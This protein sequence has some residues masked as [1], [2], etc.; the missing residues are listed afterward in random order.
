MSTSA[1]QVF[2]FLDRHPACSIERHEIAASDFGALRRSLRSIVVRLHESDDLEAHEIS[3][4]L[5]TYLSEWLTVP[6]PFDGSILDAVQILGDPNAVRDRWGQ[7]IWAFYDAALRAARDLPLGEN[8]VRTKLRAVM[9]GLRTQGQTFKIYCHRRARP[10]FESLIVQPDAPLEEGIFLDSVRDYRDV[11]PF[12]ALIKVGPLRSRGWGSAPDALISA[13]RFGTLVQIVWSGCTD[14]PGFGYDPVG[15]S[16]EAGLAPTNGSVAGHDALDH[17]IS[18]ISHITRSGRDIGTVTGCESEADEF[19]IFG[20]IGHTRENRR[21]T[22]VEIEGGQGIL[23]PPHSHVLSFDPTP[24]TNEPIGHRLPGETLVERMFVILPRHS[25]VDLGGPDA[26]KG[27]YSEAWKI[28]LAA[29]YRADAHGLVSQLRSRGINLLDLYACI[30]RWSSSTGDVLPAPGQSRHFQILIET[31]GIDWDVSV[32]RGMEGIPWWK[33]AWNEI[34]HARGEAI[35]TGRNEHELIDEEL[36]SILKDLLAD[37]QD[38]S[39]IHDA[40]L[41][42]IPA[43]RS[44]RGFFWF[45]KVYSVEEGFLVPDS[46]L[47]LVRELNTVEQWRV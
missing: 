33:R 47:R 13:P 2:D 42:R 5:R 14:E 46:E 10:H 3:D 7:D 36:L 27:V 15:T 8:P 9:L 30:E 35:Q 31:L 12:D 4:R 34:R 24:G 41:L 18:W 11:E 32:P 23:Y 29:M 28:R 25:D 39:A 21:A 22:L 45:C 43:D 44:L 16:S 20:E 37:I 26:R 1:S 38:L 40:Y 17:G 19:R 6:V